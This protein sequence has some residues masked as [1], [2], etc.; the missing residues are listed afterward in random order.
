MWGGELGYCVVR[1]VVLRKFRLDNID[2]TSI[3]IAKE[4][5]I[6]VKEPYILVKEPSILVKEPYV[7]V[8]F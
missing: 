1:C 8:L 5:S 3:Q 2:A 4:P 7:L 6:L